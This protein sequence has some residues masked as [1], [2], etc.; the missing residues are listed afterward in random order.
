MVMPW[1]P[2]LVV[3]AA[4]ALGSMGL[5][6]GGARAYKSLRGA[7]LRRVA[8]SA[9]LLRS[10]LVRARV[11]RRR[12]LNVVLAVLL[13]WGLV[14]AGVAAGRPVEVSV[15]SDKLA[16]RDIVLCL[17]VSTSMLTVDT[18]V[19]KAFGDLLDSFKGERVAL[20]AWN[21]TAQTLVP[22]T[23][24]YDLLRS[25]FEEVRA[26]LDF[27]PFSPS[28]E[29]QARYTETFSGTLS[30][31][32][33]GSSLAGDGL[34]SCGMVFDATEAEDRSRSIVLATDN[35]VQDLAN[36]QIYSLK[37]AGEMIAKRDVRLFSLYGA[38]K[39]LLGSLRGVGEG[40]PA[41]AREELKQVTEVHGGLFYDV[42]DPEAT[43]GIVK[44]L[45]KEQVKILEGDVR[46]LYTDV[47]ERHVRLLALIL[48]VFLVLVAWRRA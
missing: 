22:L 27:S 1:V 3:L 30:H 41:A 26:A 42:T 10:E 20:V 8:N 34:A 48:L 17:D 7:E 21:S 39:D 24:D 32:V 16:S 47:P 44:E 31:D 40:A 14:H 25:Q 2:W 28:R 19:L 13:V 29:E 4:L 18:E 33:R 35:I 45:E 5:W 23:D 38:D 11:L 12:V 36:D 15:R 9:Q 37:D 6:R 43:G 46:T